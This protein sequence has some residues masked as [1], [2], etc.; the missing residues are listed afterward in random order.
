MLKPLLLSAL[1]AAASAQAATPYAASPFAVPGASSAFLYDIN[2]HGAMVGYASQPG[3]SQSFVYSGGSFQWL[4]GPAGALS[5]VALGLSDAGWV[6]GAYVDTQVDDGT[7]TLVLGPNKGFVWDGSSYQTVALAGYTET[8]VRGI[9]PDGRYL[10]GYAVNAGVYDA[11]LMDRSSGSTTILTSGILAIAQ[12]VRNDGSV[13]GSRIWQTAPGQPAQRESFLYQGG[14]YGGFQ[15]S[16]QTDTRARAL[17]D[18]GQ[19]AG[20]VRN[21]SDIQAFF[22]ASTDYSLVQWGGFATY[23][24]GINNAGVGVGAYL[25]ANDNW[26]P[27]IFNPVPEP[28]SYALLLGGLGLLGAVA[29]RRSR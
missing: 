8:V 11:W 13:V 4:T 23:A 9:S 26:Q 25:D 14:A 16:G 7:G 3:S 19:L 18:D 22:G 1:L 15:L 6:V 2:N 5:T 29:R 24:E 27:L 17:T 21:G 12:G 20:W 10:T 28:A